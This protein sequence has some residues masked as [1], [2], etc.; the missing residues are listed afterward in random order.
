MSI[1]KINCAE[2]MKDNHAGC[3]HEECLCRADQHGENLRNGAKYNVMMNHPDHEPRD[4]EK[5]LEFEEDYEDLI[6]NGP[7]NND[8]AYSIIELARL[9][10][11]HKHWV[12]KLE[13]YREL[14]HWARKYRADDDDV[15][16]A[17][18][19]VFADMECFECIKGISQD[20]GRQK[21]IFCLTQLS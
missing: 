9:M 1:L 6:D 15:Q 11:Y 18:D 5:A 7:G 17:I 12:S 10:I 2:C 4:Y 19:T 8:P 13:L 3:T 21:K 20:L 16:L 14:N